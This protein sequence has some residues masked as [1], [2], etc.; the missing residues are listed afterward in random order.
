MSTGS[1]SANPY[2]V[3]VG[4]WVNW[5]RGRILGSTL[6][7]GRREADLIIAFT[8]F[9]VAFVGTRI[10]R[11]ICFAIHRSCSKEN[12]QN[13]IYHQHQAILRN[14]STP[15]DGIQ[16]L[17]NTLWVCKSSTGRFRLLSTATL[18]TV[19]I[20]SFTIAGGFSSYISTGIGNEVLI[21][22]MNCGQ[23]DELWGLIQS[24]STKAYLAEQTNS[25]ASY[26]QQCY[27]S[28]GGGGLLDCGRFVKK[29]IIG[30]IDKN[31]P[32]PFG[33][34]I[35]RNGSSNLRIDSGYLS[36]HDHFGLNSPPDE[37][38]L[39]RNVYHCAPIV[40]TGYTSQS[41][42]SFGE[43]TLYHYGNI[44]ILTGVEDYVY[45]A[46]S[47]EAQYSFS[48]SNSSAVSYS[49]LD[50]QS[51]YAIVKGG[52]ITNNSG[53]L[54]ID[55]IFREDADVDVYFLSGNGVF[56]AGPS[57]DA[58]Y[59]VSNTPV[60]IVT[61]SANQSHSVPVY[62]PSEPSSPLGCTTQ[63]Q[64]CNSI[65]GNRTC[66]PLASLA[67]AV[68]G[69]VD[70]FDTDYDAYSV[71]N[72]TTRTA[73]LFTYFARATTYPVNTALTFQLGATS[74]ASQRYL[75]NGVQY[76]LEENQ[77]QL[78]VAHWWAMSMAAHQ[79]SFLINSYGPT[80]PAILA[81]R[82]NYTTPEL[83]KLCDNQKIRTTAYASFSLFGLV[84]IFLVGSILLATSYLL[85]PVSAFLY[86]KKGYKKYEHLEWTSNA[87]LQLQRSAHEEAGFGTWSKCTGAVPRTEANELLG[88]LDITKPDHPVL[89]RLSHEKGVPGSSPSSIEV[90]NTWQGPANTQDGSSLTLTSSYSPLLP[91]STASY[92]GS[93]ELLQTYKL[94]PG[95]ET[96]ELAVE[97]WDNESLRWDI[98]STQGEEEGRLSRSQY[99]SGTES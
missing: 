27:S 51:N 84:F 94:T 21:K 59:R 72:A 11:I 63:H 16:L 10:W 74:L 65:S 23:A 42:T 39:W 71:G 52:N 86:K 85:E 54:P 91:E 45:A 17:A 28:G 83:K 58:W 79:E 53:V 31:A 76:L 88:S 77:W 20:F 66:G 92:K 48:L 35:C 81:L 82:I 89:Q 1:D 68:A 97:P 96:L 46:K 70:L 9:F 93:V 7:V 12:P 24:P 64:F 38:I 22:S 15:E 3:Y 29:E 98:N 36:S 99:Y 49:N 33:N 62:L 4:V 55:S 61:T 87:T 57:D 56:F 90:P 40:T 30:N 25:A 75:Y 60:N 44:T 78:D 37:R 50:L 6:T 19:C 13:A 47:L 95:L 8:A 26:A 73:A 34:N 67:D 14:S 43:A 80:D 2:P 18:A 41:N 69:V 5:S 32:C